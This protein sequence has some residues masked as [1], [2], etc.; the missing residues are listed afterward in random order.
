MLLRLRRI[1]LGLPRLERALLERPGGVAPLPAEVDSHETR[2][3]AKG[4]ANA[5]RFSA[6]LQR[7]RGLSRESVCVEVASVVLQH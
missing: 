1:R 6:T 3:A 7:K 2:T 5:S 4:E